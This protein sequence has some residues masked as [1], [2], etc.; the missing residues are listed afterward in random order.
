VLLEKNYDLV[1]K[2]IS[3]LQKQI[4]TTTDPSLKNPL[5]LQLKRLEIQKNEFEKYKILIASY[6]E[7]LKA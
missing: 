2:T 5:L 1:T 7:K 3:S 6:L 4:D